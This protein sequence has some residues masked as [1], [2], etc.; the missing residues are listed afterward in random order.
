MLKR[1][2]GWTLLVLSIATFLLVVGSIVGAWW[3]RQAINKSGDAL[4]LSAEEYLGLALAGLQSVDT[5]LA[6]AQVT[7]EKIAA[8][9]EEIAA[10]G[11]SPSAV[12]LQMTVADDIAPVVAGTEAMVG[13]VYK[14]LQSFNTTLITLNR[15]PGADVP[16]FS[17]QLDTVGV[18]L[19]RISDGLASVGDRIAESDGAGII[20]L[21]TDIATDIAAT[22]AQLDESAQMIGKTES[23]LERVRMDLPWY[24]QLGAIASTVLLVLLAF[25]QWSLMG[26]SWTWANGR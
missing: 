25:G 4:L 17:A 23:A 20:G 1:I 11:N 13:G 9:A 5:S 14:A 3:G 12:A 26:R 22:R 6:S 15:L 7:V 19:Q 2:G 8:S 16:T 21:T 18:Q 10:N 24:T